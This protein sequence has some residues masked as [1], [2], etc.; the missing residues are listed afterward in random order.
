MTQL[1]SEWRVWL[2]LAWLGSTS[3]L[4]WSALDPLRLRIQLY[5]SG[6]STLRYVDTLTNDERYLLR[7]F[8]VPRKKS[9]QLEI[10]GVTAGLTQAGVLNRATQL[11]LPIP[12]AVLAHYNINSEVYKKLCETPKLL[13]L[14]DD[15]DSPASMKEFYLDEI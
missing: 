1:V 8:V 7:Q 6:K 3:T 9:G 2:G 5:Q 14:P 13:E 15:Y 11:A 12:G 4:A 10:D